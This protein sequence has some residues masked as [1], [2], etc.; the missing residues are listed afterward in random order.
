[1]TI[2][3]QYAWRFRVCAGLLLLVA[4]AAL[5]PV[6]AGDYASDPQHA[7]FANDS[8]V[9]GKRLAPRPEIVQARLNSPAC[10]DAAASDQSANEAAIQGQLDRIDENLTNLY[11]AEI[12]PATPMSAN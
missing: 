11:R 1:M 7:C 12:E 3:Y 8:I 2:R 5:T 4:T 9:M 10:R 6:L